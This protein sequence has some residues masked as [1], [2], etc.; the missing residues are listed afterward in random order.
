LLSKLHGT[1][2]ILWHVLTDIRG[3]VLILAL[4]FLFFMGHSA[5]MEKTNGLIF[6]LEA[7]LA[8]APKAEPKTVIVTLPG[9]DAETFGQDPETV[10][11]F[12]RFLEKLKRAKPAA[13]AIVFDRMPQEF[14]SDPISPVSAR[15]SAIISASDGKDVSRL[16]E[17]LTFTRGVSGGYGDLL[18]SIQKN[19]VIV[20]TRLPDS[21]PGADPAIAVPGY[22]RGA[23]ALKVTDPEKQ[24]YFEWL[25]ESAAPPVMP[26]AEKAI[27]GNRL[28][29]ALPDPGL[30]YPGRPGAAARSLVWKQGSSY[31]PFLVTQL[32]GHLIKYPEPVW[33]AQEGVLFDAHRIHTD[34]SGR[35]N[36]LFLAGSHR[37]QAFQH[38]TLRE[39]GGMKNLSSLRNKIVLIG[40]HDDETLREIALSVQSLSTGFISHTPFWAVWLEK[41]LIILFCLYLVFVLPRLQVSL[42]M[43]L[44]LLL[45]VV[46]ITAQLGLHLGHGQ[47]APPAAALLFFFSGHVLM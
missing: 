45:G 14:I 19:R 3:L 10:S 29:L 7:R 40:R 23:G 38:M 26:Y 28:R 12:T 20:G 25:P 34:V 8:A 5:W 33:V 1:M 42:G 46:T 44:S 4:G 2:N 9:L 32:Y 47:W 30:V 18:A 35:V 31:Y 22:F 13:A 16:T 37:D 6:N 39:A 41:G 15:L 21:A 43:V 24:T 11:Q 17:L 36:F 27:D